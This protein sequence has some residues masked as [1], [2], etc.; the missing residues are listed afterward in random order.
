MMLMLD[1]RMRTSPLAGSTPFL[2]MIMDTT[3]WNKDTVTQG[4]SCIPKIKIP[5]WN[6]E[7]ID[8]SIRVEEGVVN[9]ALLSSQQIQESH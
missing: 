8:A 4:E 6:T 9:R 2:Q 7:I 1:N 3:I 5:R